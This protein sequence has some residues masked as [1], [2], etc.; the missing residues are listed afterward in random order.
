MRNNG[1]FV[2]ATCCLLVFSATFFPKIPFILGKKKFSTTSW[3]YNDSKNR[4]IEYNNVKTQKMGSEL[5][6]IPRETFVIGRTQEE[7]MGEWNNTPKRNTG[8]G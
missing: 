1:F 2:F 4:R 6:F 3:K 8:D 5:V 7:V